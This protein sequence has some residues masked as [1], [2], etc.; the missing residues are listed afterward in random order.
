[1]WFS[2][3]PFTQRKIHCNKNTLYTD[4]PQLPLW[5]FD[6]NVSGLCLSKQPVPASICRVIR[7]GRVQVF[8]ALWIA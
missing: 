6:L 8:N 1:M 5:P 4:V 3:V 7:R 2:A